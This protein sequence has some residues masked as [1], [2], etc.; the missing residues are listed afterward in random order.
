MRNFFII[1]AFSTILIAC[2]HKVA[3][4]TSTTPTPATEPIKTTTLSMEQKGALY[5]A[6]CVRC[7]RLVHP[8]EYTKDEWIGWLDKMAPKA[9]LT[10]EQKNHVFDFLAANAKTE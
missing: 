4:T 5:A 3:S 1:L 7:H 10:A 2:S 8:D 6:S 9:K